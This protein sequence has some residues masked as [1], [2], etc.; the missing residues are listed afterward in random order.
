MKYSRETSALVA[1][2]AEN[3]NNMKPGTVLTHLQ[4]SEMLD[5]NYKKE[6]SK[7][8]ARMGS[9]RSVLK[10]Q[11]QIFLESLHG[12]GYQIMQ[13]GEEIRV[14]KNRVGRGVKQVVRG[15]RDTAQIPVDRIKDPEKKT[16]TIQ[17]AQKMGNLLGL[18]K[19]GGA[20]PE[21]KKAIG[22]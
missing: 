13:P 17:E 16:Y 3:I 22:S 4:M 7:Y 14:C 20:F 18:L 5:V 6:M 12:A 10:N 15:I 2:V 19:A 11:Y 8:H 21:E 1:Q 9:V